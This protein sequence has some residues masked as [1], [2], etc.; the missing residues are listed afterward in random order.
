MVLNFNLKGLKLP[1]TK[2]RFF[3]KIE[4]YDSDENNKK[5]VSNP[6]LYYCTN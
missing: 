6:S 3:F 5:N 2:N 1:V 4:I